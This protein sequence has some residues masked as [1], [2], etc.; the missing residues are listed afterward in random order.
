MYLT[1]WGKQM[2]Q[3]AGDTSKCSNGRLVL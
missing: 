1:K 2:G 3:V